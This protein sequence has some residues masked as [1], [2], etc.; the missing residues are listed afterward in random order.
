[1]QHVDPRGAPI[2]GGHVPGAPR[3]PVRPVDVTVEHE[4][5]GPATICLT[6]AALLVAARFRQITLATRLLRSDRPGRFTIGAARGTDAPVNPAWLAAAEDQAPHPLVER[7]PAGFVVNLS[8]AMSAQL[9]TAHQRLLLRPD[10]GR[11]ETP[12]ELP[13]DARLRIACGEVIFDLQATDLP[14]ALPRPWLPAGWRAGLRYP[15]GVALAL[16]VLMGVMRLVPA[17]PRALSLDVFGADRRL[18]RTVVI[19]LDVAA[20]A[21]DRA[22][23][24]RPTQPGGSR[25]AA[26]PSGQAGASRAPHRDTRRALAGPAKIDAQAAASKIRS[27]VL[28]SLL[29]GRRSAALADVLKAGPAMGSDVQE[30]L[31]HLEGVAIADAYGIEGRLGRLGTGADAAGT[32]ERMIGVGDGIMGTHGRFGDGSP[33]YGATAGALAPRPPH[34]PDILIG[35]GSVSGSLD[36]EIIRR[37]VRRHLN[38]VRYCYDHALAAHPSLSGR[39]V[40]QFTIAPTGRVLAA[41]L[42]TSTLGNVAVESCVVAAVRRWEFPAPQAGGLASVTYPFQLSPAGQ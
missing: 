24:S 1:M 15:A 10:A 20:P 41:L 36:R 2:P 33:R 12:L 28:L 3:L 18:D 5:T 7:T 19:P 6:A 14:R 21:V 37:T 25:A 30:A 22:R 42:A 40:V 13:P 26:G 31:G 34:G 35:K 27:S 23:A 11:P 38:E 8:P 17:D 29:E 9:W 39:L 16:A 32:G 4:P